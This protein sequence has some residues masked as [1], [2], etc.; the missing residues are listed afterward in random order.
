MT[1]KKIA[2]TPSK[3]NRFSSGNSSRFVVKTVGFG[4]S[5]NKLEVSNEGLLKLNLYFMNL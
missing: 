3:T 4:I 5:S 2:L 1:K